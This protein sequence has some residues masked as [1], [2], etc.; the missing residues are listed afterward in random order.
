MS[1]I[2]SI[3]IDANV[4]KISEL[5]V[6]KKT[7]K[8]VNFCSF[9][10][11]IKHVTD[12][13]VYEADSLG[14]AI[15]ENM[16]KA[17]MK[18]KNAIF[19][20][21]TSSINGRF[22]TVPWSNKESEVIKMLT[23]T[24]ERDNVFPVDLKTVILTY[25]D[26]EI[27]KIEEDAYDKNGNPK[28]KKNVI[29]YLD[30]MTYVAPKG[31]I[32][33]IQTVAKNAHLSAM[34][35]EYKGNSLYQYMARHVRKSDYMFVDINNTNTIIGIVDD[36]ILQSIRVLDFNY[37]TFV[38]PL[39]GATKLFGLESFD[40]CMAFINKY[41]LL[42]LED[43]SV[44][45]YKEYTDF[46]KED[47][48]NIRQQLINSITAMFGEVNTFIGQYRQTGKT[49][50]ELLVI[51]ENRDFP[52]LIESFE[53]NTRLKTTDFF[54]DIV[55]S[56][57]FLDYQNEMTFTSFCGALKYINFNIE[58]TTRQKRREQ[59][60]RISMY[61]LILSVICMLGYVGYTII[62]FTD[63]QNKNMR[64]QGQLREAQEAQTLYQKYM[65]L[66]TSLD[67]LTEFDKEANPILNSY[68]D[69]MNQIESVIPV[70]KAK[71]DSI[72]FSETGVS[73]S[74]TADSKTTVAKL[75]EG[76]QSISYFQ[77]TT[78]DI[79]EEG[80]EVEKVTKSNIEFSS[81]SE[82]ESKDYAT[83]K[84]VSWSVNCNF[85][86][87]EEEDYSEEDYPEG[88]DGSTDGTTDGSTDGST[89]NME[90]AQ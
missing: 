60:Q 1:N 59:S 47:I 82:S 74:G 50:N 62:D 58:E 42:D 10:T 37:N 89:E 9:P 71:V 2:L 24:A 6:T 22:L 56:N 16:K 29:K 45:T 14:F 35:I 52:S 20:I 3:E 17:G 38:E 73:M 43:K 4:V 72:S 78:T 18:G 79:D 5:K 48:D 53:F 70:N 66:C 88:Y 55:T 81:V 61:M 23:S 63:A 28:P 13:E 85:P 44:Y 33:G 41:N 84:S 27:R 12:T 40:D 19:I 39:L 31:L 7:V 83:G 32:Q 90:S 77:Q 34:A 49:V 51:N 64:L 86:T 54:K 65:N 80:N 21:N 26:L 8:P 67:S 76:L 15:S 46:D 75:L 30:T 87:E 57:L 68:P 25:T 11:S 36:T 69:I